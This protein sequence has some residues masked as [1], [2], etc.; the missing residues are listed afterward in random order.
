MRKIFKFKVI[1]ITIITLLVILMRFDSVKSFSFEKHGYSRLAS[2]NKGG[3]MDIYHTVQYGS[4]GDLKK[5]LRKKPD[6]NR[7]DT[8]GRT[9]L[10]FTLKKDENLKRS[11]KKQGLTK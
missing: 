3:N 2:N 4:I 8:A 6:V 5:L 10:H 7:R 11:L 9:P 1:S